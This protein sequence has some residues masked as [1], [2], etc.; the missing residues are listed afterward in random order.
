LIRLWIYAQE[1]GHQYSVP[2][3]MF[4]LPVRLI[5]L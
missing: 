2:F 4:P 3:L 5:S 1:W